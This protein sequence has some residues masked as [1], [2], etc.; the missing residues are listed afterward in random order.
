MSV[1][2]LGLRTVVY[3]APDLQAAKK[4]WT[5]ALNIEPYFD[6]PF[7]VGYAVAGYELALDPN[8][9]PGAG[10]ITYWGV[11]DAEAAEEAMLSAG[12]TSHSGVKE[13]G[14]G[15][16]V[17]IVRIPDGNL[18]GLIYNPHFKAE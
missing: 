18:V 17:A 1:D 12:A 14:G 11:E 10:P 16:K 2:F 15:I 9:D 13:V 4:W 8:G 3:P 7:Y 5:S 6:E